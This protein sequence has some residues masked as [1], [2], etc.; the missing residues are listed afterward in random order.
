MKF[1]CEEISISDEESGF[2]IT[3]S[4]KKDLG[5]QT[6]NTSVQKI[7]DSIGRYLL[8]QRPYPEDEV[9]SDY[10]YFETHDL[11]YSG[12]LVGYKMILSKNCFELTLQNEI[13]KVFI[14]PNDKEYIELIKTLQIL[15]NKSGKLI[16]K[17]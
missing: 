6:T 5:K 8:I 9:D 2:Q 13:I 1:K 17:D 16:I 12:E 7:I 10:I 4:E 11:N 3:F 15:T 14:N